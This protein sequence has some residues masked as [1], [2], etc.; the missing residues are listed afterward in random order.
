M[1]AL[2]LQAS[3]F[4][5]RVQLGGVAHAMVAGSARVQGDELYPLDLQLEV[6][7]VRYWQLYHTGDWKL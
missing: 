1:E 4:K 3:G 5:G 6:E 7:A 2:S